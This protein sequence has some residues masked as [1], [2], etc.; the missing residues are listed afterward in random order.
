MNKDLRKSIFSPSQAAEAG[1]VYVQE[2]RESSEL[3]IPLYLNNFDKA[4][5]GKRFTPLR[6]GNMMSVMTCNSNGKTSFMVWHALRRAMWLREHGLMERAVVIVTAE[7]M[8]E[9]LFIQLV[10]SM[11]NIPYA[12]VLTGDLDEVAVKTFDGFITK[13]IPNLPIWIV[14][15]SETRRSNLRISDELIDQALSEIEN[16][17]IHSKH[18]IDI[19]YVDYLQMISLVDRKD[20]S[21]NPGKPEIVS[22]LCHNLKNIGMN[23]VC[24]VWVNT[25]ARREVEQSTNTDKM[26]GPA[27]SSWSADLEH[28]TDVLMAGWRPSKYYQPGSTFKA[29]GDHVYTCYPWMWFLKCYKH[30][31]G[32]SGMC[33]EIT[34]DASLA[35]FE[36]P[37]TK[38]LQ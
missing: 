35:Q 23:H 19:C 17:G 27:D 4:L 10:S 1:Q 11:S 15:H 16:W 22:Q 31:F 32:P 14:G 38:V 13:K 34:Y 3:A 8:V 36:V 24:P 33:N 5:P 20:L 6:P 30:R 25:Q 2:L 18:I 37:T 29:N 21:R 9:T 28:D 7:V 26:P 12:S